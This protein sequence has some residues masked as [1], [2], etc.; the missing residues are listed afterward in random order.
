MIKEKKKKSKYN[1]KKNR[2]QILV[3]YIRT[4]FC[5][6]IVGIIITTGLAINARN[7]MIKDIFSHAEQQQAMD[8]KTALE[9]ITQSNLLKDLKNS[10][11]L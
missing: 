6:I 3:E 1:F 11:F 10:H 2:T 4:I 5:A 7:E 9:I 8:R